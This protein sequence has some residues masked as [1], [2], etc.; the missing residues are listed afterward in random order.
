MRVDFGVL[1]ILPP[2]IRL[3]RFFS[4]ALLLILILDA[5][6]PSPK[7]TSPFSLLFVFLFAF[8]FLAKRWLPSPW[9]LA[10]SLFCRLD[11]LVAVAFDFDPLDVKAPLPFPVFGFFLL[12]TSFQ[13]RWLTSAWSLCL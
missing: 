12:S 7:N 9:I 5:K 6:E 3:R 4:F 13:K 11:Y 10:C 1:T 8:H 2:L